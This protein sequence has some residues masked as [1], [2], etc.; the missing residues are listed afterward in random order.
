MLMDEQNQV[1][2]DENNLDNNNNQKVADR[3]SITW[4]ASEF[5]DNAKN[6]SWYITVLFSILVIITLVYLFTHSIFSSIVIL[7]LGL[8]LL[9]MASLRP[10]EVDYEIDSKGIIINSVDHPFS[11]FKSYTLV[12]E[13]GLEHV[14]LVSIKRFTPNRT[15]YF[16][17]QD[18][19]KIL[20]I[21]GQFLPLEPASNE[22][23]DRFMKKIG[24]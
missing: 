4:S 1:S 14:S 24:L 3:S 7:I 19:D 17:P 13:G 11:D 20:S 23:I 10:K 21:V 22:P 15:I 16:E 18:K 5:I 12:T 9:F 6:F 8:S 2:E